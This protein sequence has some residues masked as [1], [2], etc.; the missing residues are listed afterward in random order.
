MLFIRLADCRVMIAQEKTWTL[1]EC[2]RYAVEN[3]LQSARQKAQNEIYRQTYREAVGSMLPSLNANVNLSANFGRGV[4]PETNGYISISTL[5]NNYD[6][7]SSVT[8]FDGLYRFSAAKMHR[9]N[10]LKGDRQL[11]HI[12][13][14]LALETME[15]FFNVLYYKGAMVLARQQLDESTTNLRQAQRMEEL[16]MKSVS[17]VAEMAAKEAEDRYNLTRQT[18]L[19]HLEAIRLK[20]KMNF[21]TDQALDIADTDTSRVCPLPVFIP[22][23]GGAALLLPR[24]LAAAKDVEARRMELKSA[25]GRS[26]P[27]LSLNGG[28]NTGFAR[29]MDNSGFTPFSQQ[30]RN[31]WG[32]YVSA[33]LRVPIFNGFSQSANILRGKQNV[34]IAENE[35]NAALRAASG[36]IEQAVADV[37]GLAE[38]HIQSTKKAQA[39]EIAQRV[40]QR[41]YE[42][43]IISALELNTGANRLLQARVEQL[44]IGLKYKLKSRLTAYYQGESFFDN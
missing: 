31:K 21:P 17:D 18:N 22:D 40:N 36:E 9:L 33:S 14:M 1:D 41:K 26:F 8:L 13:D 11:Q 27:T 19:L 42:E 16:G 23:V 39:M 35:Y 44:Y 32:Y 2:M 12:E 30:L 29:L 20:E 34:I 24:S 43:G 38:E 6:V 3:S 4:D 28:F 7:Y 37:N 25:K 10:Q 15:L 5:G